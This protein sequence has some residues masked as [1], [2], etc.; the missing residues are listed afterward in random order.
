MKGVFL[1][2]HIEYEEEVIQALQNAGI[3]AYTKWEKVLGKG[4]K[5][6]PK[7]DTAVWP[8]FNGAF[9]IVLKE[10]DERQL[11]EKLKDIQQRHNIGVAVFSFPIERII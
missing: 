11:A 10:E 5:S 9:F 2:Y 8:G 1:F 3:N 6:E 7:L 4:E